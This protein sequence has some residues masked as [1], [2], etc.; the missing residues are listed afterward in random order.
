MY[1]STSLQPGMTGDAVKQLQQYL[2]SKGFLTQAQMNTGP[3]IYGP[4]TTNAVKQLQQSL[5]V[6]NSSGPGYWGPK[7][8]QAISKPTPVYPTPDGRPIPTS[9]PAPSPIYPTPNGRPIPTSTPTPIYPTPDGNPIPAS[10]PTPARELPNNQPT[11][12]P[13]PTYTPPAPTPTPE[14][15]PDL[16]AVVATIP[17]LKETLDILRLQLQQK[18]E[19]GKKVNPDLTITPE[20]AQKFVND[21]TSELDPYYQELIGQHKQDLDI[22]FRQLQQDY[23]TAIQREQ[24]AFQDKLESQD[25]SEAESGTA[26]SSGRV[27]REGDIVRGQ[28]ERLDDMFNQS[29]REVQ[30]RALSSER[31]IGSRNFAD[32]GIPSLSTYSAGRTISPRGELTSTGTRSLYTPQGGLFGTVP[33]EQKTAV[34]KR[35]GELETNELN[36]RIL[37]AGG[38]L[39]TV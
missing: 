39:R 10:N 31:A 7:T 19:E 16:E 8:I 34:A 14:T 20:L 22:S 23:T 28:Q 2:V 18:L 9:T 1:P 4:A 32:L 15:N 24:P 37:D 27:K 21:A 5:G 3:G 38:I 6:D 26:F 36:K 12:N 17:A 13:T 30:S 33:A 35:A 25:I 29:Q 11:P